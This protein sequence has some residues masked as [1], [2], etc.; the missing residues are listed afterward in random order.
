MESALSY[1]GIVSA[2]DGHVVRSPI[3][4]TEI[5]RVTF[6][7]GAPNKSADEAKDVVAY[8]AWASDP[9]QVER[10]QI[11]L[12]VI[13]YLLIFAGIVYASYRRLWRRIEH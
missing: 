13:I 8:L 11:G 1:F 4:G 9:H 5:G 3:D 2:P 10:K 12:A 7:D 6:D